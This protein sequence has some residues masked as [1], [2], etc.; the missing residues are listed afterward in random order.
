M[1]TS[2]QSNTEIKAFAAEHNITD[3]KELES[4][5][6]QKLFKVLDT[7]PVN[8]TYVG[9]CMISSILFIRC[10]TS[11]LELDVTNIF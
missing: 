11:Y 8:K 9:K 1:I 6:I 7:M 3:F 5:F 4:L 10:H 2:R